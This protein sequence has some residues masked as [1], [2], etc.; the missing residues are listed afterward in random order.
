MS[1]DLPTPPVK[2]ANGCATIGFLTANVHIGAGRNLW[3]GVVGAARR[4][5]LNLICFPGG[6]LRAA[7]GYEAQRN[8]IYDLIDSRYLDGLVSW[9]SAVGGTLE[10]A[11][12]VAFHQ[13][14]Q[15]LPLVSLARMLAG[16]PTVSID[17]YQGMRESLV[18]LIEKHGCR[19]I[20][21]IRGPESH[22][23]AQERYR[24]YVDVLKEYNL[25]GRPELVA[26]PAQ[27]EAGAE[28]MHTLL[29]ENQ[30]RPGVDF[31]A[32]V[33]VSDL[34]A[35]GALRALQARG[36]RV[37]RDVAVVG[38]NDSMEG[39]LVTPPL[40]SVAMPF[41]EQGERA[42]EELL[43]LL[44]GKEAPEQITLP[45]RLVVRQSCG[46]PS[47]AVVQAA[48]DLGEGLASPESAHT[49]SST[50]GRLRGLLDAFWADLSYEAPGF[51]LVTLEDSLEAAVTEDADLTE[52]QSAI[53]DLRRSTIPR[54]D[55]ASK[56]KA[57]D[58]FEQARVMIGEAA[59]RA[60]AYH[61]FQAER[62]AEILRDIGQA[63]ITTF[64]MD[65]LTD[66]L[67][68]RLPDI[69]IT[70]CYLSLYES[71]AVSLD[72]ARLILAYTESGRV[73]LDSGGR[74]FPSRQLAPPDLL[75]AH[76]PYS[77]VVEPF[78]FHNEPIGFGLFEIG[79]SDGAIY[80][81]LRGHVSSA[82]KGA[83]LFREA[84]QAR[85]AAE[86][87][88]QIKTRL[89]ANVSHELRTPLNIIIDHTKAGLGST[90][91]PAPLQA[92]LQHIQHSAEHQL[93]VINDLLDL[94]RAEID[95]LDLY[96]EFLNP[97][98]LL[99]EAF[100]S[101]A[102]RATGSNEVI[103]QLQLPE[104]LPWIHADPVR[105]RQVL[106]NLLS[107][108]G[109]FTERGQILLGAETAPPYLHVWVNDTGVGIPPEHQE[110]V[111][112]P[113]ITA[114]HPE[115]QLPGGIGLGLSIARHIVALH[116]GSMKLDSQPGRGSTFHVYLPLPSLGDSGAAP[117]EAAHTALLVISAFDQPAVEIARL[118]ERQR[119]AIQR[120]LPGDDLE[121]ILS[122]V[123]PA[124]LAWDLTTANPS[125]WATVRRLR[126]HPKL[127]RLPFILYGQTQTGE[128]ETA[129]S[130]GLTS[131]VTKPASRQTLL[132]AINA[133][134]PAQPAGPIL[135]VDDDPQ[136][137]ARYQEMLAN[138]L[139]SYPIRT[140]IDGEAALQIMAEE[141]PS[142]VI[143]DLMMPGLGGAD[144]L[145][146]MRAAP[147][148][149]LIPVVILSS[150][151][152]NLDDV[153]RLERHAHVILQSKGVLSDSET[154]AA[155]H[156]ALFGADNLPPHTGALV[157]RAVAY[158]HQNYTRS[159]ARWE[160]AEAIGVSE[161]YLTRVF[162]RE[163]SLSP[164]DYLNRYRI[165]QAKEL[166]RTTND[167]IRAIARQVGFK[168]QAYFSRVFHK[169]T[170]LSPNAF[171]GNSQ[172]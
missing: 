8:V 118:A 167:N 36:V 151:L 4:H 131:F 124:A 159:L 39:R 143:L 116:N 130:V 170:G 150:K 84:Q 146:R 165:S 85:L 49:R 169:V 108:A 92:D 136:A 168:D 68:D 55:H 161:D 32:V 62:Q 155:F 29:V 76:R 26:P 115:A 15:P 54:L 111:F 109:K 94:S 30:L 10:Q 6:G 139:P 101:L 25:L 119:L 142:L 129:L 69:G 43:T 63:L 58:I 22:F 5:N 134:A 70:S 45:T 163:L 53:S 9:A 164:W 141:T 132:D 41:Y 110:N 11:E 105:L 72:Q 81:V 138:G 152:L 12:V 120:L 48:L 73:S 103:W 28:S 14:Y 61:Q 23:Y 154:V 149:R 87:A 106:F 80:E 158:L 65:K 3:P 128:A 100:H 44:A 57:E 86:K 71:P 59:Q 46:C 123:R 75:P 93:R 144:V 34:L 166:L 83:L 74:S 160:I 98:P 90:A 162:N 171:R 104:R 77:L 157:K 148:L 17:S 38:F 153:R 66:A 56:A 156:R 51:F 140:A 40:T 96:L 31:Q 122:N 52:W 117:I 91:S 78:F 64:D 114:E 7:E 97:R 13:R 18:H 20:A 50:D 172:T 67:A 27:W 79:P 135:I 88:D 121:A 89:L 133:S 99:E 37:P 47:E 24:A 126:N 145:D 1:V 21:F 102:D 35:L 137:R 2:A 107:N 60:Q 82:M 127:S 125:D 19:K 95:A 33:A 147:A 112:E 113:F 16:V 42:V